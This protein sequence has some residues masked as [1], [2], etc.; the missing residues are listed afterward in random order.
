[1]RQT[2]HATWLSGGL[3]LLPAGAGHRPERCTVEIRSG[4]IVALHAPDGAP[5]PAQGDTVIDA[6]RH[7]VSPGLINAHT[8]SPDNL[9]RGSAPELPL[10]LWSL[11]SAAGREARTEREITVAALLGA[12]EMLRTGTTTVLDHIRFSPYPDPAGLDAVASAYQAAGMRAIIAPVVA[13]KPVVETLPLDPADL[14]PET[15][16][17]YGR[18]PQMPAAEQLA[19]VEAFITRWHGVEGR[20][21][22]AV[23]PSGPQ[24]CSGALLEGAAELSERRDV[25]LHTHVLETRAQRAMGFRLYGRGMIRALAERKV[26][27]RRVNLV[28]AIWLEP[29]DIDIVADAGAAV[30]HN[31]VSNARLGSGF[32]RLPEMLSRGVRVALGTDSACCNDSNNLLETAKWAAL[33]HNS[34]TPDTEDWVGPERALALAT[35]G[36]ADALGLGSVTGAIGLGLSADLALIRLDAPSFAPLIDPVRQ[37]VQAENGAAVDMVLVNGEV[38]LRDGHCVRVDEKALWAEAHELAER[39]LAANRGVYAA[40]AELAGPIERMYRRLDRE[41]RA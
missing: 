8:H 3:C 35:R 22:G 17:S 18:G 25:L 32:C 28:H 16:G 11:H 21:L 14:P 23:G 10:E 40:A 2:E 36:G 38:V 29:G 20:I 30:V 39:R 9:I 34:L 5:V 6:R 1:M 4:R 37:L 15:V 41:E 7:L 31:P 33:V 13:D 12:V 19:L 26:L 27:S 24:R